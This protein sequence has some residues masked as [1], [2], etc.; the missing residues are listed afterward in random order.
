MADCLRKGNVHQAV[1]MYVADFSSPQAVFCASKTMRLGC[2]P[3]PA[4]Q[5]DMDSFF[6]SR[7]SH[8]LLRREHKFDVNSQMGVTNSETYNRREVG[9]GKLP[10]SP[11]KFRPV[12]T[13]R[14]LNEDRRRNGSS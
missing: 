11:E 13:Y 8:S 3:R 6:C 2:D 4:L 9:T 10:C 5:N 1:A 12:A 14:M 7:D